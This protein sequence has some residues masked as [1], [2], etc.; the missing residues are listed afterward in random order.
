MIDFPLYYNYMRAHHPHWNRHQVLMVF[1][2]YSLVQFLLVQRKEAYQATVDDNSRIKTKTFIRL[3]KDPGFSPLPF[4][5]RVW[6][7]VFCEVT[8][9]KFG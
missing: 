8:T 7:T 3:V 1:I 5:G 2:S 6:T 4:V 9:K